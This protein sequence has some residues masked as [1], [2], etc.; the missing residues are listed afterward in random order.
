MSLV[1]VMRASEF[2]GVWQLLND[3]PVY[4]LLLV[5]MGL[6]ETGGGGGGGGGGSGL[7]KITCGI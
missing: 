7:D 1:I 4:L 6:V 2:S 5:L 3:C